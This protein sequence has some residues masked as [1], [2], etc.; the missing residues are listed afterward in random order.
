MAYR[1]VT[2]P[3]LDENTSEH[4]QLALAHKFRSFRLLALETAPG[5]FAS[6]YEDEAKRGLDHTF[7]RLRHAKATQFVALASNASTPDAD[8]VREADVD[9][10]LNHDW[11]GFIVLISL[12]EGLKGVS[13]KADPFSQIANEAIQSEA[14]HATQNNSR[15]HFHLNGMFVSPSARRCGMGGRLI[16]AALDTAGSMSNKRNDG[17]HC[18]IIVDEWNHAAIKL[19]KRVGFE[20]DA[21]E[22]Y[23]EDRVAL[24]MALSRDGTAGELAAC[25]EGETCPVILQHNNDTA[26]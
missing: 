5:A 4:N 20:I 22:T 7:E 3:K 8:S 2:I 11:L 10:L 24:R 16:E 12:E 19:Y 15:M 26:P 17:F 18:T 1:I 25:E 6:S 14:A 21:K 9:E 23:G 13:A